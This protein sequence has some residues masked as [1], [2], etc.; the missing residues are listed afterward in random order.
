MCRSAARDY[1]KP[2]WKIQ[3]PQLP[4]SRWYH[5]DALFVGFRVVRPLKE[6]DIRFPPVEKD[7]RK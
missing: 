7:E 3:D 2:E 4:K 5:T 6:G 1:S